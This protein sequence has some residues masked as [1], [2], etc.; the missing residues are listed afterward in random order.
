VILTV[1]MNGESVIQ[2][3]NT[4]LH[5]QYKKRYKKRLK[6]WLLMIQIT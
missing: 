3:W 1:E 4:E 6:Y 2:W 5:H